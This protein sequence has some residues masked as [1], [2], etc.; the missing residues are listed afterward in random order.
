MWD[1]KWLITASGLICIISKGYIKYFVT[2]M[3]LPASYTILGCGIVYAIVRLLVSCWSSKYNYRVK[4]LLVWVLIGLTLASLFYYFIVPFVILSVIRIS[5]LFSLVFEIINLDDTIVMN[6]TQ[7]GGQANTGQSNNPG[8]QVP[9]PQGF[10]SSQSQAG[11]RGGQLNNPGALVPPAGGRGGQLNNPGALIPQVGG[12]PNNPANPA[13]RGRGGCPVVQVPIG[14]NWGQINL[15][16]TGSVQSITVTQPNNY[17]TRGY[18]PGGN[19][20]PECRNLAD[21]LETLRDRFQR[22]NLNKSILNAEQKA[23]L[24]EFLRVNEV[25]VYNGITGFGDH[26]DNPDWSGLNI[27]LHLRENLRRLS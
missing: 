23:F 4:D 14:G 15:G 21:A 16:P 27:S 17:I 6:Y 10:A 12:Q 5:G 9:Q 22:K 20:Q 26:T 24:L 19:N 8:Q 1:R 11:G 18:Q 2:V 3:G 13:G 7:G 25:N